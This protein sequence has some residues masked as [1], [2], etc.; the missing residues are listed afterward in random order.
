MEQ[1]KIEIKELLAGGS[2]FVVRVGGCV[3]EGERGSSKVGETE[4][5]INSNA[6]SAYV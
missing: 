5:F 1:P 4:I 6:F 3:W 2:Y